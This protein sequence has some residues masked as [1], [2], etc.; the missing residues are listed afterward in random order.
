MGYPREGDFAG[1]LA[2]CI[3]RVLSD[4][5]AEAAIEELAALGDEEG[6]IAY[7]PEVEMIIEGYSVVGM[8]GGGVFDR[9]GSLVGVLERASYEYDGKQ[10]VRVVRMTFVV[11]RINSAFEAL[12]D[13]EKDM[14]SP[15]LEPMPML[16]PTPISEP[17]PIPSPTPQPTPSPLPRGIFGFPMVSIIT[18]LVFT[19]LILW[20]RKGT[21]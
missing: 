5:E 8:S 1:M 9:G 3:G 15:Y 16:A 14:V 20:F 6:G 7:D 2:A 13:S 21:N 18:G 19:I 11:D 10:Y 12:S 4:S 17:S